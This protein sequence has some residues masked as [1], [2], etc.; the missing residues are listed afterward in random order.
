MMRWL[1]ICDAFGVG[2][3]GPSQIRGSRCARPRLPSL[4]RFAVIARSA[5]A[6]VGMQCVGWV[7]NELQRVCHPP[8]VRRCFEMCKLNRFAADGGSA[9]A[10]LKLAT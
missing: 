4:T 5:L 3:V 7:E 1:L 9:L 8:S 6:A 2:G 10:A